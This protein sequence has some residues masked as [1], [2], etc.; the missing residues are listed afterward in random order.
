MSDEVK[1]RILTA[2]ESPSYKWRTIDGL[3]KEV[4]LPKEAVLTALNEL[5]RKGLVVRSSVPATTGEMLFTTRR[6][7]REK[8][9]LSERVLA[10]LRNRGA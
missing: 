7:Y 3:S 9:S 2:L 10:V 4:K 5:S 8:A 6:H 1:V